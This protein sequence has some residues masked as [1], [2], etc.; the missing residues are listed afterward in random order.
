MPDEH[1]P[2]GL[3]ANGNGDGS[4]GVDNLLATDETIGTV[5]GN[6]T[7][8]VLT[9][10]LRDLEDETATL[11]LG[12]ALG[13]LN[14]KSVKNGGEVIRLEVNVNDGTNDLL[15][16]T[17]LEGGSRSVVASGLGC[18]SSVTRLFLRLRNPPLG[19]FFVVHRKCCRAQLAPGGRAE[20][21]RA[22]R[23]SDRKHL[24]GLAT[25]VGRACDW[26]EGMAA[27]FA[28]VVKKAALAFALRA[29]WPV[30]R[31]MR[32]AERETRVMSPGFERRVGRRE[33]RRW[34]KERDQ[35][36]SEQQ[37]TVV[38]ANAHSE[39]AAG[40]WGGRKCSQSRSAY[41]RK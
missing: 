4:T 6:G 19:A 38:R 3:G 36:S 2:K 17:G 35:A 9:E 5:H 16:G 41:T 24:P 15:D 1:S 22:Q 14:V 10:V 34:D 12:L 39:W 29:A 30:R 27:A 7:D 28:A 8:S 21:T 20:W 11:G 26:T 25:T 18:S 31:E 37:T 33:V 23:A 40:S 32:I 13:K